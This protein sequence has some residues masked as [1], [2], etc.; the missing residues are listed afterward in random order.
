MSDTWGGADKG[1]HFTAGSLIGL[2]SASSLYDWHKE[3]LKINIP[4]GPEFA[5]KEFN[6]IT[7]KEE[8]ELK[9]RSIIESTVIVFIISAIKEGIDSS[10]GKEFSWQDITYAVGG[11]IIINIPFYFLDDNASGATKYKPLHRTSQNK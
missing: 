4:T 9:L 2:G 11:S 8:K 1:M 6:A 7:K 5:I 10:Q 3:S